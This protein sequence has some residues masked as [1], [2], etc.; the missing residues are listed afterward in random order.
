MNLKFKVKE[1]TYVNL[2]GFAVLGYVIFMIGKFKENKTVLTIGFVLMIFLLI[3][4]IYV[5]IK[6][7]N[8]V[9]D[10]TPHKKLLYSSLQGTVM[11]VFF[12]YYYFYLT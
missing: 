11:S 9:K 8:R 3:I 4:S 5:T 10:G 7:W 2:S 6:M 1:D 12:I